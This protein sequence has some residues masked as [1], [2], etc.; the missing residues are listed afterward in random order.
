MLQLPRAGLEDAGQYVCTASNSAGQDQ[1]SILLSVYGKQIHGDPS[2]RLSF[3]YTW[4]N[5]KSLVHEIDVYL[6]PA[7][8]EDSSWVTHTDSE[9]IKLF[10]CVCVCPT[11]PPSL[12]PRHDVDADTVT[13]HVGKSVF[14]S[15]EAQGV[16]EPEVT[17][18]KNGLQLA[19]GNRLKIDRHQLEII[20]VQVGIH[21]FLR[22]C[23]TTKDVYLSIGFQQ[24]LFKQIASVCRQ[25]CTHLNL[26]VMCHNYLSEWR[27]CLST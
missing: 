3:I 10:V 13:P 11:V 12:K 20:G 27:H 2:A 7:G 9:G 21:S 15:C 25:M 8:I 17:W 24:H 4:S 23:V 26:W 16:P 5:L 22:P 14:L 6:N 18:Y 1:K 19:S